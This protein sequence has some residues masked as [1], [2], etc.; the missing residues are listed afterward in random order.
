M[1]HGIRRRTAHVHCLEPRQAGDAGPVHRACA[2]VKRFHIEAEE[3]ALNNILRGFGKLIVTVELRRQASAA[4]S[5][6]CCG[7]LRVI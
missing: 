1:S 2:E 3:R 5:F 6:T 7:M 4:C